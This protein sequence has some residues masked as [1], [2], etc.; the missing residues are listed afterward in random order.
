MAGVRRIVWSWCALLLFAHNAEAQTPG[1]TL[2]ETE[3]S[4]PTATATSTL[5]LTSTTFSRRTLRPTLTSTAFVQAVAVQEVE[6]PSA[7]AHTQLNPPRTWGRSFFRY[8]LRYEGS[9]FGSK[10][11]RED[12]TQAAVMGADDLILLMGL[13]GAVEFRPRPWIGIEA[14][15]GWHATPAFLSVSLESATDVDVKLSFAHMVMAR[16]AVRTD[17][18]LH[19]N[20]DLSFALGPVA[21]HAWSKP[22]TGFTAGVHATV[23]L[24]LI[25]QNFP[26]ARLD[27]FFRYVRSIEEEIEDNGLDLSGVGLAAA[28]LFG[29]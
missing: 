6:I 27:V 3:T 9:V 13:G 21:A 2:R 19:T 5:T 12:G 8:G 14:N 29:D 4:T 25:M 16:A 15:A 22:A 7:R 28:I 10:V 11:L 17:I 18:P 20:W 1:S 23:G 24:Q 26:G